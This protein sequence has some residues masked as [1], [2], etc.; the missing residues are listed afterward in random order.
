[1]DKGYP[2]FSQARQL[3]KKYQNYP[4]ITWQKLFK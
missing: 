1:V 3:S 4:V 2:T